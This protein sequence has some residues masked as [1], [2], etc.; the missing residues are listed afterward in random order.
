M[1]RGMLQRL[2]IAAVIRRLF[3][4]SRRRSDPGYGYRAGYGRPVPRRSYGAGPTA[5][6]GRARPAP[7]SGFGMWGPLP[8]YSRTTRGGSRVRVT[9]CCLPIPLG[10]VSA[11]ALGASVA[12]RRSRLR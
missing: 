3:E 7:R 4:G 10:V 5:G 11:T 9:G 8:S 6:W 2:L 12:A 1:R